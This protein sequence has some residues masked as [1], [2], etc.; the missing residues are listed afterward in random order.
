MKFISSGG[1]GYLITGE[2]E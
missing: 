1:D 2:N